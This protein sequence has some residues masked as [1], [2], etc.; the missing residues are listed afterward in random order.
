MTQKGEYDVEKIIQLHRKIVPEFI[1]ILEERYNILRNIYYAQPVGR[2]ALAMMLGKGERTVRAQVDFLRNMGLVTFSQMGM[3]VTSDGSKVLKELDEYI[4]AL[5]GFSR[6]EAEIA[7]K[8][9]LQRVVIIPGDSSSDASVNRELGRA[10]ARILK[11]Y[12]KEGMTIAISGG[13]TMASLAENIDF[14]VPSVRVVPARGGLGEK[15]E[16][17]ANTIAAVMADKLSGV[18]RQLYV[19]DGVSEEAME[20]IL[21]ENASVREVAQIIKN[22]DIVVQ[23]IGRAENMAV[24]R[25]LDQAVI[26]KVLEQGAV[27]ETLGQ[28]CTLAGEIVFTTNSVGLMVGDLDNI[29][30]VIAVAGGQEKAEAIVAVIRA[31]RPEVLVTDESAA[32]AIQAL[33]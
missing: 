33:I 2:R 7:G 14:T 11:D 21:A 6:I 15:V 1:D 23:G 10:T 30:A 16:Y 12:V 13:S 4:R 29:Q 26:D 9:G 25:G 8:L 28:Y 18:Y 22:A 27:G 3:S 24:R 31:G 20:V 5:H 17:Q 19:P 32:K